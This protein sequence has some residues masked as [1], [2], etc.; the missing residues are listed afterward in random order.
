MSNLINLIREADDFC[1]L[2]AIEVP[3]LI[4]AERKL[5]VTFANDYKEYALAFGAATFYSRE[6]TGVCSSERLSVVSATERARH[7]YPQSPQKAYVI[8][9]LLFDHIVVIQD[10][11]GLVFSYGPED[12]AKKIADSLEDYLNL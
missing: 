2:G 1:A 11:K 6:L 9:E 3:L 8:E 7:F 10:S 5:G 4:E 12:K